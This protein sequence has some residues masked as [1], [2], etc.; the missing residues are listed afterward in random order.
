MTEMPETR[1]AQF[2]DTVS[3]AYTASAPN[4]EVIAEATEGN[5][6][7][8]NIGSGA[9]SLAVEAAL[10]GMRV[11]ESR[12]VEIQP[13]DAFGPYDPRLRQDIPRSVFDGRLDPKPGMILALTVDQNGE[14]RQ[15]PATV[16]AAD[17]RAVTVDYNH[18]LA[19]KVITYRVR[20][21]AI[22]A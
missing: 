10:M 9:L 12:T 14:K 1:Q 18:P 16:L 20:L 2:F 21:L 22:G 7:V 17:Q 6:L 8:V 13:E 19:G 11:G 3:L 4:G 5:P 15:A